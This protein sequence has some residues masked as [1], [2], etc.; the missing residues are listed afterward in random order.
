MISLLY[1]FSTEVDTV[2]SWVSSPIMGGAISFL[3]FKVI[4]SAVLTQRK[5]YASGAHFICYDR[6]QYTVVLSCPFTAAKK[7]CPYFMAFT[8]GILTCFLLLIGPKSM[9]YLPPF[10]RM[11]I[12]FLLTGSLQ[13]TLFLLVFWC[14]L[15]HP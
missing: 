13:R 2:S 7:Y 8:L 10:L 5:P 9:R 4:H 11:G 3:I 15:S 14:S 1:G 6:L 12:Y